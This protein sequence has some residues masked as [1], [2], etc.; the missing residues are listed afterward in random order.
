MEPNEQARNEAF[1]LNLI[2]SIKFLDYREKLSQDIAKYIITEK[3]K[4]LYRYLLNGL[5]LY[6]NQKNRA[7]YHDMSHRE[8]ESFKALLPNDR[9]KKFEEY[10]E[11]I[12]HQRRH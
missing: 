6:F 3:G 2:S 7:I 9:L 1:A 12:N 5:D 8:I 10:Y 11:G 4:V